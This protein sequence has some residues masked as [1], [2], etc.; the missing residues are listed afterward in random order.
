MLDNGFISI[1]RTISKKG[2]Y[3]DSEYIHLWVHVLLSANYESKEFLFNGKIEIAK[4]GQFI[5]GIKKLSRETG[6]SKSKVERVLKVFES[7]NQIKR[8]RTNKFSLITVINYDKFQDFEKQNEKQVRSKREASEKQVRTTKQRNKDNKDNKT[9]MSRLLD[10]F[11]ETCGTSLRLTESKK[12]Q[13]GARLQ[14]FSEDEIKQ[15]I[16]KRTGI[17][18][19]KGQNKE[20]KMWYKDWDSLFRNDEKVEK[21]LENET[22]DKANPLTGEY[23]PIKDESGTTHRVPMEKLKEYLA[24]KI[25]V[26]CQYTDNLIYNPDKK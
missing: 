10:F 6:I 1:S 5:T 26:K 17:P 9:H 19:Y 20:N 7:E 8:Q 21:I 11:N 3:S 4:R 18:W 25:V 13:I 15:A 23:I 14:T 12:R 16:K 2:Y 24:K 22:T